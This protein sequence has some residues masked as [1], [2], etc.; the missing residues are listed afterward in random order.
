MFKKIMNNVLCLLYVE[1]YYTVTL[2]RPCSPWALSF[3]SSGW[4]S[5]L[6]PSRSALTTSSVLPSRSLQKHAGKYILY[7]G[8]SLNIV[9]FFS[10]MFNILRPLPLQH[11]AAIGCTENGQPIRVTV[12]SDQM[13]CSPTCR[14]LDAVNWQ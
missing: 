12:H 10:R 3:T 1:A 13:S 5:C 11:L 9:G 14:G 2:V 7:T 4:S 8:C 6:S